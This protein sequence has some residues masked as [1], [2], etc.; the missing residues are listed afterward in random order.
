MIL[1]ENAN[2]WVFN[3]PQQEAKNSRFEIT[4]KKKKRLKSILKVKVEL[5]ENLRVNREWAR[6]RVS[7]QLLRGWGQKANWKS[8]GSSFILVIPKGFEQTQKRTPRWKDQCVWVIYLPGVGGVGLEGL[9]EASSSCMC[10]GC[11]KMPVNF[12]PDVDWAADGPAP[13]RKSPY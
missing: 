11:K 7:Q 9:C 12:Q 8:P 4:G 6:K 3:S 1:E 13:C 5:C 2:I 10:S